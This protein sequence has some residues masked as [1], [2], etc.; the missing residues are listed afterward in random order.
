MHVMQAT[1]ARPR[2]SNPHSMRIAALAFGLGAVLIA[3]CTASDA[4]VRPPDNQLFF[5]TGL[6]VA[7]DES[8]L[9][10]A[11]SNSE[12][13]YDSGTVLVFDLAAIKAQV[14]DWNTND[15]AG[16][17]S[18]DP[19]HPESLICDESPFVMP[20]AGIRTGNFATEIAMQSFGDTSKYRLFVPTRG[21]PSVA[22]ADYDVAGQKLS[23][24]SDTATFAQCDDA[25]RLEVALQDLDNT[26]LNDEPF[27]VFADYDP[28]T[29]DGFAVISHQTNGAISLID[30]PR[31]GTVQITDVKYNLFNIDPLTGI[32]GATGVAGRPGATPSSDIIY[33]SSRTDAR[34]QTLTIGRPHNA[35]PPP[36]PPPPALPY[37]MT[38]NFLTLDQVGVNPQT[39]NG[40]DSRGLK[41]S[42]DG[43]RMYLVTR[44]PPVLQLYDT[45][46]AVNGFPNNQ[47]VG[48][49]DICRDASTIGILNF[50][51]VG[52]SLGEP[53]NERAYVTCFDDGVVYVIDPNGTTDVEDIIQVGRGPFAIAVST[54]KQLVFVSNFSEDTIA[55]IDVDPTS[56]RR[57]RV[58]LR[59]GTPKAPTV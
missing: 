38:S 22:W 17:C 52:V 40:L 25:H 20:A 55:V 8:V 31:D 29:Q 56:P 49:S 57:N 51:K 45:S 54:Q 37:L 53:I 16:L 47:L 9:F 28:A 21:D 39:G 2:R 34:V 11:S 5:P 35:P 27:G 43:N 44:A 50:D 46:L 48:A 24:S 19:D 23:C 15:K 7:P 58:V 14:T 13:R 59:I 4:D 36:T 18:Q 6:A 32:R 42:D 12:L 26:H 33:V 3:G 10:A 30:A 41:F 1:S